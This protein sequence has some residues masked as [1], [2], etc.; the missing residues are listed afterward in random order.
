MPTKV[1]RVAVTLTPEARKLV[2]E[3]GALTNRSHSAIVSELL[4]AALPALQA[5]RDALRVIADQ[6]REAQRLME[7][8]TNQALVDVAQA[9]LDLD[10]AIDARTVKGKRVRPR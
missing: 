8:V 5:V 9:Q 4:D 3:V 10:A 6:P 2:E 7:R 1:P